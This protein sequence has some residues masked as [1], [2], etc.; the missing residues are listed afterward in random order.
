VSEQNVPECAAG[1]RPHRATTKGD[2]PEPTGHL[3]CE[4]HFDQLGKWL[5]DIEREAA[6]TQR[7]EHGIL[8][9]LDS[10][11]SMQI[12]LDHAGGGL[13]SQQSPVRLDAVVLTDPRRGTGATLGRD[14]DELAWDDTPSV[15]N[16]LHTWARQVRVDRHLTPPTH[17]V[18]LGWSRVPTGPA[19]AHPCGHDS[20]G[21]WITDEVRALPTVRS[22]REVLT[23]HLDWIARQDWVGDMW[24]ELRQL[25]D[26]LQSANQTTAPRPHGRC[27]NVVQ[28][29]GTDRECGGPLWPVKPAHTAGE[30]AWTGS[31]P[32]AVQCARCEQR[33]DGPPAMARLAITLGQR[34]SR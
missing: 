6:P 16:T 24:T 19:C 20:C 12:V 2:D 30:D 10:R 22:E 17:T 7:L 9:N 14:F 8:G 21:Q 32:S 3:L 25:R 11:P 31:S 33:W 27:P 29:K 34:R 23:R 26:R 13:A 18:R 1:G 28:V 4:H 5:R 15:L